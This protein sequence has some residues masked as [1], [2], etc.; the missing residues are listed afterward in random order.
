M[1]AHILRLRLS[2]LVGALRGD[3]R[4]AVRIV[5]GLV[6]LAAATVAACVALMSLADAQTD[7]VLA[8]TVLG[9]SAVTKSQL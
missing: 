5:F 7:V 8:V 9:G 1:V 2:L 3:R 6:A 4:R